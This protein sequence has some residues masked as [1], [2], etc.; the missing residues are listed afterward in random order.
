MLF[1]VFRGHN[2]EEQERGRSLATQT[3][4]RHAENF[5]CLYNFFFV[6]VCA[7]PNSRGTDD[8]RPSPSR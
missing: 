4:D 3:P 2:G 7:F 1:A 8:E 6:C 5:Y